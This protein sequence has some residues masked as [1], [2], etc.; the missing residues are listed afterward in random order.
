MRYK[1]KYVKPI[2][3]FEEIETAPLCVISGE[4]SDQ[5]ASGTGGWGNPTSNQSI[6]D[7]SDEDL[8]D[9]SINLED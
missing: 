9:F 6:F 7:N 1:S 2:F 8:Y 5:E 3:T 4:G